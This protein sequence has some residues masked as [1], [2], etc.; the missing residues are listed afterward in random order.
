MRH[1]QFEY[2]E[3]EEKIGQAAKLINMV[4]ADPDNA[5]LWDKLKAWST[6]NKSYVSDSYEPSESTGFDISKV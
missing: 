3:L 6:E 5:A 2:D 4:Y 1:Q